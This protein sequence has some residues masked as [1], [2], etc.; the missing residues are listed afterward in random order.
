VVAVSLDLGRE[1]ASADEAR[2]ICGLRETVAA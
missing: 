2:V 1:V